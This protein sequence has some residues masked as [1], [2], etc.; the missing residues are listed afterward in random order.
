MFD[1]IYGSD[2]VGLEFDI[3]LI[4]LD[5]M[6]ALSRIYLRTHCT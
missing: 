5:A 3:T 1:A 4:P 6:Y 2:G